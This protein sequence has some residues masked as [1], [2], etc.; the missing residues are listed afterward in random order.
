MIVGWRDAASGEGKPGVVAYVPLDSSGRTWGKHVLDESVAVESMTTAD[1]NGDG[2]LD[3]AVA[4][5]Q[6]HNVKL[7]LQ[8]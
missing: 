8:R 7:L 4:G 2:K 1:F 5:R 6:T 3:I